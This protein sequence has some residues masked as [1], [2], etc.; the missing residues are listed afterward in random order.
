MSITARPARSNAPVEER[1]AAMD[2]VGFRREPAVRLMKNERRRD[3]ERRPRSLDPRDEKAMGAGP[4]ARE[5]GQKGDRA[6][7]I[8]RRRKDRPKRVRP[9]D[10]RKASA[11]LEDR[12]TGADPADERRYVRFIG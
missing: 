11:G 4:F 9:V 5:D 6:E 8:L 7:P 1:V 2:R 12:E 10:H 3:A